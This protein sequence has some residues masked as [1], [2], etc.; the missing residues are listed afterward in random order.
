MTKLRA[1]RSGMG[2]L[3]PFI[4]IV[5]GGAFVFLVASH[6]ASSNAALSNTRVLDLRNAIDAGRTVLASMLPHIRNNIAANAPYPGA[7]G[8]WRDVFSPPFGNKPIP[9]QIYMSLD[10]T[11]KNYFNG[12]DVQVTAVRFGII[13][14]F[15]PD[16]TAKTDSLSQLSFLP[17]GTF[18]MAVNASVQ[19]GNSRVT[20]MVIQRFVFQVNMKGG[21]DSS[22]MSQDIDVKIGTQPQATMIL[23]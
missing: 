17:Q 2:A 9:P 23:Q 5:I 8:G 15:D 18:A 11:I 1:R 14:W 6:F 21:A 4:V 22:T 7:N 12:T 19:R 20:R 3:I 10:N 16:Y 13:E